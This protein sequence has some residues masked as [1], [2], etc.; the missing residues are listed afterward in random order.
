MNVL[1]EVDPSTV[2]PGWGALLLT[3]LIAAAIVLLLFSMRSRMR[4]ITVPYRDELSRQGEGGVDAAAADEDTDRPDGTED[5]TDGAPPGAGTVQD[6]HDAGS[7]RS[8]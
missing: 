6:H 4:K 5:R 2:K 3:V 8:S 1:L 7:P